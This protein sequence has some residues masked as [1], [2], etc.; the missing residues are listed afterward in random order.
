MTSETNSN[1]INLSATAQDQSKVN[2][3]GK[4]ETK[5]LILSEEL[6]TRLETPMSERMQWGKH[7][8]GGVA[9]RES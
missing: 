9:A 8:S 1:E 7:E 4:I 2:L 6:L 3:I 5:N